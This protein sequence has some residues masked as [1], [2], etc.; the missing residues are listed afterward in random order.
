MIDEGFCEF[1]TP[2]TLLSDN[3]TE[4]NNQV[5]EAICKEYGT[6]KTNIMAYHPARNELVKR[7]NRKIMQHLRTLLGDVAASWH[8]WMPQVIA[9]LN[10]SLHK[11]IGDTPHFIV[12]GQDKKLPYSVLLKEKDPVYNFDDHV[13]LR[14]INSQ[15]IYKRVRANIDHTKACMS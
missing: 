14:T 5:L 2:K 11:T 4:F 8:E 10:T 12:F 6:T 13:R 9:S 3:G 1:N 7:Q 15:N